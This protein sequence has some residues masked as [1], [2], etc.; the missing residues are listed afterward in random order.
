MS[1]TNKKSLSESAILD[2]NAVMDA[3]KEQSKAT[4]SDLLKEEVKN[5]MR[6][7]ID[8]DDEEEKDYDVID[9]TDS[10]DEPAQDGE[11][12][13]DAAPESEEPAEGA[14]ED[15]SEDSGEE[16][17]EEVPAEDGGEEGDD[18]WSGFEQ[19]K[20]DDDT[21]DLTGEK[22]YDN[23]VKV[24]KLLKD[25]DN[26]IVKKEGDKIELKDNNAGTEY[27]IDFG[28]DNDSDVESDEENLD[29]NAAN[30]AGLPRMNENKK[31]RK[32]MKENKEKVFEIDLGYTDNYQDKDPIEGL[33]NNEPGKGK[34][35][36]AGV[37]TG[38]KKPWAGDAKSKS[39]PYGEKKVDE[40]VQ[41]EPLGD[42]IKEEDVKECNLE[43]G[44][45]RTSVKRVHKVKSASNEGNPKIGPARTP[46][47]DNGE[48]N[49]GVQKESKDYKAM[50]KSLLEKTEKVLEENKKL[51]ETVSKISGALQESLVV[52]ANLGKVV[53]L[54]KECT[55]T[56]KEKAEI[57][58]RFS[59]EAKTLEQSQALYESMKRE[60]S[61]GV[62]Q[63][64]PITESASTASGSV[65]NE[66]KVYESEDF[67][68]MKDMMR[69]LAN[70]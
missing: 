54:M 23:V 47:S 69:R 3:I 40:E 22:D 44:P 36:D 25:E 38:T 46:N 65:I 18:E 56:D 20:V 53:R 11:D 48:L 60:L 2:A 45:A 21:Y 55:T 50:V 51:K 52:N 5:Y 58:N 29:E 30:V 12:N 57:I 59:N 32:A 41:L 24:F 4:I 9:N 1:A 34:N 16:A 42:E 17:A 39:E 37:P 14:A 31:N 35:W 15:G 10:A 13:E 70:C 43:E 68:K 67:L 19:Y 62:K 64:L 27:V 7:E 26:V 33:N 28:T 49:K 63:T 66:T 8:G 6:D 61:K